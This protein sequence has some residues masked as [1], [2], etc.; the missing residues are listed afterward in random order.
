MV[1]PT[2][3][4][5]SMVVEITQADWETAKR[6]L[7]VKDNDA[8]KAINA[9]LE[10]EDIAQAEGA[11][12]WDDSAWATD[13]EGVSYGPQAPAAFNESNLR[14]LGSSAA[15]TRGSSPVPSLQQPKSK[16]EEDDEL[17][18]ALANSRQDLGYAGQESGVV[19]AAGRVQSH[20]KP[21]TQSQY[22]PSQWS[23]VPTSATNVHE[24]REIIPDVEPSARRN[25]G[26]EPRFLKH[27]ASGDYLPALL[28]IAHSIPLAREVL[29]MRSCPQSNY[30]QD[31]DWWRGHAIK[32]PQIVSTDT[33]APIHTANADEQAMVS[34]MQRLIA[35]LDSSDRSYAST[36]TLS[37]LAEDLSRRVEMV[38]DTSLD[39]TLCGWEVACATLAAEDQQEIPGLD[40]LFHSIVGTSSPEG[41][42]T[43]HMW[44]LPLA[45]PD[46]PPS[47]EL[48]LADVM[49]QTLWDM[50]PDEDNFCDTY[51]ERC[52]DILPMRIVEDNP[53]QNKLNL[54]IPASMY[55]DKYL[56]E[57]I[58]PT[59][60]VRKSMAR[61]KRRIAQ[62]ES[63]QHELAN[64]R[65]PTKD[66]NLGA[67][68]IVKATRDYFTGASRD[69]VLAE[70][71]SRGIDLPAD[72]LA[73][74][75]QEQAA[76]TV[77]AEK[78]ATLWES[79][80]AKI[81]LLEEEKL[82]AKKTLSQLSQDTPPGLSQDRLK[83]H[84]TLRGV[85][86]KPNVIYLLRPRPNPS[87]PNPS[88][89]MDTTTTTSTLPPSA[90]DPN[91]D[92]PEAPPG[93]QWWRIELDINLTNSRIL[94]TE[95]T[96]DDVLRAVELEHNAAL[97][98]YASDRAINHPSDATLPEALRRFVERDNREFEAELNGGAS[99]GVVEELGH[100]SWHDYGGATGRRGSGGSTM[101]NF[102]DEREEELPAYSF[103][104]DKGSY[105]AGGG[106]GNEKSGQAQEM[107]YQSYP[108]YDGQG[109]GYGYDGPAQTD[110]RGNVG[111]WESPEAHEIRLDEEEEGSEMVQKGPGMLAGVGAGGGMEGPQHQAAGNGTGRAPSVNMTDV[112]DDE[113]GKGG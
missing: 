110:A 12:H 70:N 30:G 44:T 36:E 83:H 39:R 76:H 6:W 31:A 72:S 57:N 23:M 113:K 47:G 109:Q 25:D 86:T 80:T 9:L 37:K 56:K 55:V 46:R 89:A 8:E 26:Y 40:Q 24:A 34:E 27:T 96:T 98:V 49:D 14:P 79:I 84:Y 16:A 53:G 10:G 93:W 1:E 78:L 88:E 21:A 64:V 59:R 52:A 111:G 99:S 74:P 20:F 81:Q 28:T 67:L 7:R 11:L 82:K 60:E 97:L 69:A 2:T 22:D 103:E 63:L 87:N 4:N 35:F 51:M 102:D 112:G 107:E 33:G 85:S 71:E 105:G 13:R 38:T 19:S 68:D 91:E 104:Q 43:P 66:E 5:I 73:L 62:L 17:E 54:V 58:E 95:S 42:R 65:H 75:E 92:D 15:P 32:L 41:V 18:K 101:V 48:T 45:T 94:K 29:L 3:D 77:M 90:Q 100:S 50:D 61:A 106:W 108:G